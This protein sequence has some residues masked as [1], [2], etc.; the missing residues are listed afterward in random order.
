[1]KIKLLSLILLVSVTHFSCIQSKTGTNDSIIS[2]V[3]T[4]TGKGEVTE[5]TYSVD[6]DELQIST[7]LNAEVYKSNKEEVV[8]YAPSDLMQHVVVK[9]EGRKVQVKIESKGLRS[10]STDRIKIKVYARDFDKLSATSSG[11]I[12]VKDDFDFSDL[13]IKVSSS[14]SIKANVKAKNIN[15]MTSSS[16]DFDGTVN[17][18]N[19][20]LQISSSGEVKLKGNV[21]NITAQASSS[22]ELR[23]E[24]LTADNAVLSTSSSAD[25]TV[26]VRESLTANSSSSGDINVIK[27]GS[28]NKISKNESSSGSINIR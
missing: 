4:E 24:N 5:K 17:A 22:G 23:G 16:G 10:I 13:D 14:G 28:L 19:L 3:F 11:S 21:S 8:V 6:F 7:S 18:D 27:K 15:V 12:V 25:I 20:N 9:Q 1:M 26:G 2:N